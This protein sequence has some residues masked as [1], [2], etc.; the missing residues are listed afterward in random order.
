MVQN[1]S[2]KK[3]SDTLR[4]VLQTSRKAFW[5]VLLFSAAANLLMLVMPIYSLQVLDRVAT[6]RSIET[7]MMLSILAVF[8]LVVYGALQALRS[9]ILIRLGTWFDEQLGTKFLAASIATSAVAPNASGAQNL[10]DLNQLKQFL[11][12]P[13]LSALFDAPWSL[14]FLIVIFMIHPWPFTITLLGGLLLLL[15]AYLNEKAVKSSLSKANEENIIAMNHVDRAARNAEVVEA[16]GMM[17]AIAAKWQVMNQAVVAGQTQASLRSSIITATARSVRMVQQVAIMGMGAYLVVKS[18]MTFGGVIACS[19]MAGRALAPFEAAMGAWSSISTARQSHGRLMRSLDE[20]PLREESISLPEPRGLIEVEK[21][22]YAPPGQKLPVLKGVSF[23]LAP[24]DILG[25]IG[26]SAAGKSTL[27]KLMVG[28]WRA[29]NGAVRL[30]G[31]DVYNWKRSEFG[32][33]IGYLPQSVELF[34]GTV[35]ENIARMQT[36]VSDDTVIQAAQ[37]AGAHDLILRLPNGYETEIGVGGSNLSAGQRQR[38]GL[39]RAFYGNPKFMV[40]DEPNSNLDEQ[41]EAALQQALRNA[42]ALNITTVVIA[43]RPTV[44]GA[45]DKILMLRDGVVADFGTAKDVL[46]KYVRKAP[47]AGQQAQ[48]ETTPTPP[49]Q[50]GANIVTNPVN[51][52]MK[53]SGTTSQGKPENTPPSEKK[54]AAKKSAGGSK[55]KTSKK[56]TDKEGASS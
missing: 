4:H 49:A 46:Q 42:K 43:H 5:Y 8:L 3:G 34:D 51:L 32:K 45:V 38:I 22:M 7:L 30:D 44:L 10:R 23:N 54:A 13:G 18:E 15:A 26:P 52:S 39:A 31:A 12:G 40:L 21:L 33:H 11:T 19:I 1:P 16:M 6:S 9:M 24:G 55:K 27:A 17:N 48:A 14:I 25:V 53:S 37:V 56:P 29:Q 35:R 20:A 36:D 2:Q 41:G 28:V 50:P 47:A